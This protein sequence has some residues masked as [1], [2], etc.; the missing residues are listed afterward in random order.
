VSLSSFFFIVLLNGRGASSEFGTNSAV[1]GDKSEPRPIFW[2]DDFIF[3]ATKSTILFMNESSVTPDP[4]SSDF[5]LFNF[6]F[7][8]LKG[9]LSS[10]CVPI[11]SSE[12]D[13]STSSP[14][15]RISERDI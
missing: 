2:S 14:V 13:F 15:P 1:G 9:R 12:S 5:L 8:L 7:L 10:N 3:S 6:L 4:N 11:D